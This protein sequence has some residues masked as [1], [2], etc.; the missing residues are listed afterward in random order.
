MTTP[1]TA[2]FKPEATKELNIAKANSWLNRAIKVEAEGKSVGMVN[3]ALNKAVDYE[4]AAFD[5]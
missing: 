1:I 2:N 4:N 5:C 3:M